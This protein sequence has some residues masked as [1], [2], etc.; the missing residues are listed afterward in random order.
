MH[1]S[2]FADL[3]IRSPLVETLAQTGFTTPTP[4][5]HKALPA[6]LA[7]RDM[8][9]IAQTG[10]GKT[11]AFG[12]P[13]LQQ[14]LADPG[15]A[16]QPR[17][18]ILAPTRE[19]AAQIH[20]ELQQFAQGTPLKFACIF[21]GVK[22]GA[23]VRALQQG[24]HVLTAT[25]GRLLDLMDQEYVDLGDLQH[26]VLD[27]ADR[28]LDLGFAR[29]IKRIARHL[30]KRRQTLLFSATMPKSVAALVDSLLYKPV[31]IEVTPKKI[32][33]DK[34]EQALVYVPVKQKP[35]ALRALLARRE[36]T[37]AVV[38]TRTKHEADR[39]A[40][41]LNKSGVV[42]EAIHGNKSQNARTRA[43]GNFLS[44]DAWVLVATDIAARGIDISGISHV[45]N[46]NLPQDSESYVHR[47]GRTARAGANGTAWSLVDHNEMDKLRAVEKLTRR[48]IGE[49][50]L[51]LS[52]YAVE[53]QA[54]ETGRPH[55]PAETGGEQLSSTQKPR[56]R[57]RRR[58]GRKAVDAA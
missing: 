34:I 11:A 49:M 22:Q 48:K 55:A 7:G 53:M 1:S 14:M 51:D 5:Q 46:Y 25:P 24:V 58:R 36:V 54:K 41:K 19:L 12:L 43:L 13:L 50:E 17:A 9:G 39:V 18:L 6:G 45:I 40:K 57:R 15:K 42:A 8:V 27:E 47:I 28:L 16:R 31:R 44:G 56:R 35:Y 30:P 32:T 21:G 10:T 37:K 3:G 20:Q 38:F 26:L 29:D 4:I 23:Q 33:A 2:S 52:D